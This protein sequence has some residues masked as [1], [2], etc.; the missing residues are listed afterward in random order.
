LARV[1]PAHANDLATV[2][3]VIGSDPR[4]GS[5]AVSLGPYPNSPYYFSA[6]VQRPRSTT[7]KIEVVSLSSPQNG[8]V[9]RTFTHNVAAVVDVESPAI[10]QGGHAFLLCP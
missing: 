9:L 7:P 10:T 5:Y 8:M 3:D 6:V 4:E 2:V 1:P